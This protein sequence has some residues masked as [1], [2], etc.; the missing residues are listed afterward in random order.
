MAA[1]PARVRAI[2]TTDANYQRAA[3]VPQQ[4][5]ADLL[6]D[7]TGGATHYY[8]PKADAERARTDGAR[9]TGQ[10]DRQ[11]NLLSPAADAEE[12]GRHR[13]RP[14][15]PSQRRPGSVG[16]GTVSPMAA[17]WRRTRASTRATWS[18]CFA[19]ASTS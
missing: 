11:S 10:D 4:V 8:A 5:F 2:P 14:A 13:V 9:R 3:T 19:L 7:N 18:R 16:A 6:P 1:L 17:N 12:H 15:A